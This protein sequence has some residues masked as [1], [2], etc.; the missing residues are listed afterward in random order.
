MITHAEIIEALKNHTLFDYLD[1]EIQKE[2]A[3]PEKTGTEQSST[4]Q[5]KSTQT[6]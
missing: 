2:Q 3:K 4:K 6:D 5:Y 1:R